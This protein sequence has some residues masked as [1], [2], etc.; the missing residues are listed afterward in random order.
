MAPVEVFDFGNRF[1]FPGGCGKFPFSYLSGFLKK[2][3]TFLY[4]VIPSAWVPYVP[5]LLLFV[6]GGCACKGDLEIMP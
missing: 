2:F 5:V 6:G 3:V 1:I 4:C